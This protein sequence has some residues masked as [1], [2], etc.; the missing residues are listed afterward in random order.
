ML[1]DV[2]LWFGKRREFRAA[3]KLT[4]TAEPTIFFWSL[5]GIRGREER[6][7]GDKGEVIGCPDGGNRKVGFVKELKRNRMHRGGVSGDRIPLAYQGNEEA[8]W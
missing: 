1:G 3:N 7:E 8:F 4:I 6:K 2:L 5:K